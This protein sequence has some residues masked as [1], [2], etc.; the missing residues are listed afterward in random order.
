MEACSVYNMYR[1]VSNPGAVE[2]QSLVYVPSWLVVQ[3]AISNI[4]FPANC[5]LK[6][7]SIPLQSAANANAFEMV[8]SLLSHSI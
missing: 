3:W 7:I 5:F 8:I 1:N 4:S 6:N 2:C